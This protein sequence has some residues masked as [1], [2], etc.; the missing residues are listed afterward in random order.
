MNGKIIG[1][2][3][4]KKV[5]EIFKLENP[6]SI[7]KCGC[8]YDDIFVFYGDLKSLDEDYKFLKVEK[9]LKNCDEKNTQNSEKKQANIE[10]KQISEKNKIAT[11]KKSN[12]PEKNLKNSDENKQ[13]FDGK[14]QVNSEKKLNISEKKNFVVFGEKVTS[15]TRNEITGYNL[16]CTIRDELENSLDSEF[17]EEK[18]NLIKKIIKEE[19]KK[20]ATDPNY[21]T[22]KTYADVESLTK[23]KFNN[24]IDKKLVEKDLSN[25]NLSEIGKEDQE[26]LKNYFKK[27][28]TKLDNLANLF[29]SNVSK[30]TVSMIAE[31][32]KPI[33][34]NDVSALMTEIV[35][36]L[37]TD[38]KNGL[39]SS[40]NL[41]ERKNI[42]KILNEKDY[43][44]FV[45]KIV[46]KMLTFSFVQSLM[47][48]KNNNI[49]DSNRMAVKNLETLKNSLDLKS[50][51]DFCDFY[52]SKKFLY[53]YE[54]I[55]NLMTAF[56]VFSSSYDEKKLIRMSS[57]NLSLILILCNLYEKK[58]GTNFYKNVIVGINPASLSENECL[59]ILKVLNLKPGNNECC[60]VEGGLKI[61]LEKRLSGID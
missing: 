38:M 24:K 5:N 27:I 8:F 43:C 40:L 11:E 33:I 13:I 36:Q 48:Q 20:F 15:A 23:D 10:K 58:I 4:N 46:R 6:E 52:N 50:L 55:N 22:F 31:A 3:I 19:N 47:L 29:C 53:S 12:I 9:I 49:A 35:T 2:V 57:K 21:K 41:E 56:S 7:S 16:E 1:K 60:T 32:L 59:L 37:K 18:K 17:N 61:L 28:N 34:M 25:L 26:I 14:S 51:S 54:E 44:G 30:Q 42:T 45:D 39:H